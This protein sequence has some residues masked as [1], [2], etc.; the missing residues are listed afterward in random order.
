MIIERGEARDE[1][2][3]NG[4]KNKSQSFIDIFESP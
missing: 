3:R 2:S 4:L 1:R